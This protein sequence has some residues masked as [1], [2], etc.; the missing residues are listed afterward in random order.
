M[1]QNYD[2]NQNRTKV[3]IKIWVLFSLSK[4]KKTPFYFTF[5]NAKAEKRIIFK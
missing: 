3:N 4:L 2:N 1:L 5:K